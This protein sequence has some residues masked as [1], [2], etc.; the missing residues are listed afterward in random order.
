MI[1]EFMKIIYIENKKLDEK[2]VQNVVLILI[3]IVK[4]DLQSFIENYE[5]N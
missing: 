1:L 3:E 5:V 4:E 2:E